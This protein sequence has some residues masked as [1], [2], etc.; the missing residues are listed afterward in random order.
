VIVV[1]GTVVVGGGG[2]TV[3]VVGTLSV[4]I[5]VP[6][7][8]VAVLSLGTV[9]NSVT[10]T[11]VAIVIGTKIVALVVGG[12]SVSVMVYALV[13]STVLVKVSYKTIVEPAETVVN[14]VENSVSV[15]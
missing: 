3:E 6:P 14:A 15:V 2:M 10:A 12:S 11:D 9:T 4:T 5:T 1:A 7:L 8:E 13:I